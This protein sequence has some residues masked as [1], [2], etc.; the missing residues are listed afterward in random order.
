M[1]FKISGED[2]NAKR[3]NTFEEK[4]TLLAAIEILEKAQINSNNVLEKNKKETGGFWNFLNP[5]KCGKCD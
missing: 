4:K 3:K 2:K 5:F 1:N